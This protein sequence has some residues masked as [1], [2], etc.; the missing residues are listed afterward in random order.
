MTRALVLMLLLVST[1]TFAAQGRSW[2]GLNLGLVSGDVDTP[3]LPPTGGDC[4]EAGVFPSFGA[5][6]TFAGT[7]AFRLRG[8]VAGENTRKRPHEVATLVG[9]KLS[10]NWYGLIGAGRIFNPDDNFDGTASG[11]AWEFVYAPPT[12]SSSGFEFSFFGNTGADVDFG[13]FSLGVRFGK[14][15]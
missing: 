8:V 11:L 6:L 1:Q 4:S 12:T 3:C 13:G 10:R 15:R 14:L 5:N 9:A 7:G 2:L